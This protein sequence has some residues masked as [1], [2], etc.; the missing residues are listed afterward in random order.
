MGYFQ[1]VWAEIS[2]PEV[3]LFVASAVLLYILIML[4]KSGRAYSKMRKESRCY[5]E[6]NMSKA[7][8]VYSVTAEVKGRPA[9]DVTYNMDDNTTS[10]TCACPEGS[11]ENSFTNI[12]YYDLNPVTAYDNRIQVRDK[13]TCQCESG[14][15]TDAKNPKVFYKGEPGIKIFMHNQEKRDF[16]DNLVYGVDRDVRLG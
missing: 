4:Y 7:H 14:I 11:I 12:P 16:F 13:L 9:F 2:V 1:R 6:T 15:S 3:V 10:I 8:G 5:K